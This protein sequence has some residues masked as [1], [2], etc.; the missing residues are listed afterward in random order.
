[1]ITEA[2]HDLQGA[3]ANHAKEALEHLLKTGINSAGAA[4]DFVQDVRE[5]KFM[6]TNYKNFDKILVE[7]ATAWSIKRPV[8]RLTVAQLI[9]QILA[10]Q[11]SQSMRLSA[12]IWTGSD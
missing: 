7:F 6:A 12:L 1:M 4:R 3:P 11:F 5:G 8:R 2:I 9:A 10:A